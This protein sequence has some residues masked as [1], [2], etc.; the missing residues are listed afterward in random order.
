MKSQHNNPFI[1]GEIGINANA[2]ID[3]AKKLIDMAIRCGADAVKFQ[4]RTV[5]KCYTKEFLD[6]P[7]ESP[8]GTTYRDEK[9]GREF[10]EAEYNEIDRYCK[11]K[12]DWFASAWDIESLHFLRKYD[13]KYNKIASKMLADREFVKEVASEGK[14]T[15]V[16]TGLDDIELVD[17]ARDLFYRS[18]CP[19]TLLHC[20]MKYPCPLN[21]CRL[22]EITKLKERYTCP[23][24]YSSHFP[25]I[26]D[27]AVAVAL[28]A[29]TI[30][31]HITLDRSSYGTDQP[32]SLEERGLYLVVRDCRAVG[33][34]L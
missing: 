34:M 21:E 24:G 1:I 12:I 13:L 23:I 22:S 20:V 17:W 31:A 9:M 26:L 32:A 2:D 4:K 10:G 14:Y 19:I 25:G 11:G 7:K 18:N 29:G 6:S 5:D 3:I 33:E 16:S 30:E 27:K 28:G 15:F 8:W